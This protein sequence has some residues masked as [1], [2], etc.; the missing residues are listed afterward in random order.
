MF[1]SDKTCSPFNGATKNMETETMQKNGASP[2]SL[3]SRN[4]RVPDAQKKSQGY[5]MKKIV[6]I[7]V[8]VIGFGF[9]AFAQSTVYLCYEYPNKLVPVP[10]KINNQEVFTLT[11][12][13]QKICTLYQ[14]G[15]VIISFDT[16]ANNPYAPDITFQWS[17][18]IQLT[19]SK[20]SVHYVKIK[21]KG[22]NYLQFE[23][24]SEEDGAKEFAKKKYKS[25]PDYTEQPTSNSTESSGKKSKKP[26]K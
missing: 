12:K 20:G 25:T 19:L 7:L 11:A 5:G 1:E 4:N 22:L 26:T 15:K 2:K 17:D 21:H 23:E 18:E 14:E 16:P 3:T 6:M 10:I 24:L 8:A 9:G 13:T